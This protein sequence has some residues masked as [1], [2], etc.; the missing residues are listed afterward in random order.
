MNKRFR[1]FESRA[2]V[3]ILLSTLSPPLLI[4]WLPTAMENQIDRTIRLMA[5]AAG[6]VGILVIVVFQFL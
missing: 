3:H 4:H 2:I 6:L 5:F 1:N